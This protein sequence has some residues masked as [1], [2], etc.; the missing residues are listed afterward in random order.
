MELTQEEISLIKAKYGKFKVVY[1]EDEDK[2]YRAV[3]KFGVSRNALSK[4]MTLI[5]KDPIMSNEVIY[6][7]V[8]I[9][10][11]SDKEIIDR[12]DLFTSI[13]AELQS[14]IEQ[15]KTTSKVY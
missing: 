10:E 11:Y 14:L 12:G 7:D 1:V 6:R 15:K 3:L 9:N 8:V 4:A 2:T 5:D 13:G